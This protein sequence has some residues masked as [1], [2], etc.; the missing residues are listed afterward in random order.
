MSYDYECSVIPQR[1]DES[2]ERLGGGGQLQRHASPPQ[3]DRAG[4]RERDLNN[5]LFFY[6]NELS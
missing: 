2:S 1:L 5:V 3:G 6:L 4:Q